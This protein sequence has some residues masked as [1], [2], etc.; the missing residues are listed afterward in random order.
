VA[1]YEEDCTKYISRLKINQFYT[2]TGAVQVLSG[3]HCL[4]GEKGPEYYYR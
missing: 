4:Y 3:N 1:A 2:I